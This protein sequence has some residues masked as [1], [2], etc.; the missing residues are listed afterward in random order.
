MKP[1]T[2]GILLF[3]YLIIYCVIAL[4]ITV[5][6]IRCGVAIIYLLK[7]GT[8]YFSW[9]D[10]VIY[11]FKAGLAAGI[12]AGVG[13]WFLSWMKERQKKQSPPDE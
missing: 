7:V 12:P 9:S 3:F 11:S 13:V 5:L 8:F 6:F 4:F 1:T 10:D 2:V